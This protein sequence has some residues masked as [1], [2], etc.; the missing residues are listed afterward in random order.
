MYGNGTSF[1]RRATRFKQSSKSLATSSSANSSSNEGETSSSF[2]Y[3]QIPSTTNNLYVQHYH[4]DY[5][6][7]STSSWLPPP[8]PPPVSSTIPTPIHDSFHMASAVALPPS[9]TTTT[10]TFPYYSNQLASFYCDQNNSTGYY[11][12]TNLRDRKSTRLNSSH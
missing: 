12:S 1:L 9:S 5:S 8:P 10:T 7:G 6:F 3:E 4:Q 2:D 11:T